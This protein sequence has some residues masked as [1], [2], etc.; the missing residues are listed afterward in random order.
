MTEEQLLDLFAK[1]L[2]KRTVLAWGDLISSFSALTPTEK[3]RILGLIS[4]NNA[5]ALGQ[6]IIDMA[7]NKRAAIARA[8]VD[9][10]AANRQFSIEEL[11]DVLN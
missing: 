9:T 1:S 7:Q 6:A 5:A 3:D 4:S 8:K 10:Y 11:L 2:A